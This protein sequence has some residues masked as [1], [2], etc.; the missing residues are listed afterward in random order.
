MLLHRCEDAKVALYTVVVVV[1]DVILNHFDKLFLAGKAFAVIAFPFENA[2]EPFHRPIVNALSYA[3]HALLHTGFHQF[4]MEGAIG[5]L[6]TPVAM[7]Q[8][9]GTGIGFPLHRLPLPRRRRRWPDGPGSPPGP[10]SPFPTPSP[11]PYR[12]WL[13]VCHVGFLSGIISLQTITD[14]ARIITVR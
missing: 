6:K 4:V 8:R 1:T 11:L 5:V 12:L 7:E 10:G 2:P 14:S 13:I 3:G 9:M